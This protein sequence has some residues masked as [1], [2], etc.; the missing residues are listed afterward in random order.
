MKD[1]R[2]L[3]IDIGGTNIKA[4]TVIRDKMQRSHITLTPQ[5]SETELVKSLRNVADVVSSGH[6]PP[7][8]AISA[9]GV[10][11]KNYVRHMPL[12]HVSNL[13]MRDIYNDSGAKIKLDNDA[14]CF[15]RAEIRAGS[16]KMKNGSVMGI[17]I[18][19][20]IGRAVAKRGKIANIKKLEYPEIWEE[21]YKKRRTK[22][23]KFELAKFL[24]LK[25]SGLLAAYE[26]S[27][28][29]IGGGV[30]NKDG[31]YAPLKTALKKIGFKGEIVKSKLGDM[32]AARGAAL[33]W[34]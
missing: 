14:R 20:G 21:E 30:S 13:N 17:T 33:L 18:G 28:L 10:V 29:V 1:Q 7:R 22:D 15:L 2:I 12:K 31:V 25:L 8:L 23:S 6:L 9:A 3:G 32:S 19:T 4:V 16:V 26:P 24:A 11:H 27:A 34:Q 5:R